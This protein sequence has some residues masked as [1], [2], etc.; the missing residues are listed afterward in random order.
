MILHCPLTPAAQA[1][2]VG[3]MLTRLV[4]HTHARLASGWH[5]SQSGAEAQTS[6]S[7]AAAQHAQAGVGV[8]IGGVPVTYEV[9]EDRMLRE[10]TRDY[11]AVVLLLV[12]GGHG[13]GAYAPFRVKGPVTTSTTAAGTTGGT[14]NPGG[15]CGTL[16]D[17]L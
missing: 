9:L 6:A 12:A 13:T 5:R 8:E 14:G 15:V 1:E 7:A 2:W 3:A 10:L 16:S 11:L 17:S 4:P